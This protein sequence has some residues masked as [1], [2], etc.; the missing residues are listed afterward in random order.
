MVQ[1]AVS[2]HKGGVLSIESFRNKITEQSPVDHGDAAVKMNEDIFAKGLSALHP[3]LSLKAGERL[4]IAEALRRAR[5]NQTI[6][7]GLLGMSRQ[8]L[9]N[10]LN[11]E[12][13]LSD[14]V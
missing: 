2:R 5:G 1:D 3:L 8:A 11:R 13:T 12:R 4:I 10:R 7:A 9:H 6:A 14:D